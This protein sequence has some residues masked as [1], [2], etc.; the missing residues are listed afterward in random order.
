M[1]NYYNKCLYIPNATRCYE[2]RAM[3]G[4]SQQKKNREYNAGHKN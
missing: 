2:I 1:C 3:N 4:A